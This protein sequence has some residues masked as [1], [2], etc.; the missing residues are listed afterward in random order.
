MPSLK[1]MLKEED[2]GSN[3]RRFFINT[4]FDSTF[5]LLGI[6]VGATMK[7]K[8]LSAKESCMNWKKRCSNV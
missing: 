6:V 5:T 7:L 4:L 1:S 8:D 3:I 2:V